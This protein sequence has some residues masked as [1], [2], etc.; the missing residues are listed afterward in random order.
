[1][2]FTYIIYI[3]RTN[4]MKTKDYIKKRR[5]ELKL[6]LEQVADACGVTKATVSRWE[7]GDI[8]NMKSDKI[9]QLA[10]ILKIKPSVLVDDDI[11][12]VATIIDV[13]KIPLYA[14]I[15]CGTGLFVDDNIDDYIAVPNR[16]I[17]SS[18]K[19]F[20]NYASGDSMIGKGITDGDVLVFEEAQTLENGQIGAFC[21]NDDN[22]VCKIFRR[23]SNGIILL[24]SANPAYEPIEIDVMK[25]DCFRIVGKLVGSF[26]Q[27]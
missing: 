18:K 10:K 5:K 8:V 22:A 12:D 9:K 19:Y 2:Q 1:M 4:T 13:V 16:F 7:S 11:E 14:S 25:D 27:F 15:S 17:K 23:L 3:G 24:E 21:I 20:A 6:S 26:K